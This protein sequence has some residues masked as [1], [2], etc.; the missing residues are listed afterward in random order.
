V[1]LFTA[2]QS[3]MASARF[4]QVRQVAISEYNHFA[5]FCDDSPPSFD[6]NAGS[7][8]IKK[9]HGFPRGAVEQNSGKN[10]FDLRRVATSKITAS[11]S[12]RPRTTYW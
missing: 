11:T 1:G 9:L 10:Y 6:Q 2:V 4:H 12:T 5:G 7:P 3:R 8:E